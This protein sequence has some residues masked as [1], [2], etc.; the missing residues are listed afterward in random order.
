MLQP[1]VTVVAQDPAAIGATACRVLFQRMDGDS[2]PPRNHTIPTRLI[3][4][5]SGEITPD[6]HPPV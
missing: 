4:R 1:A 3:A 6:A 2:S 5:G